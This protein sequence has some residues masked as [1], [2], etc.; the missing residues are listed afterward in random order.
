MYVGDEV[1]LTASPAGENFVWSSENEEVAGVSPTGLVTALSEGLSSV[2]VRSSGDEVKIDVRVRTFI[3]L[4]DISL[5][6]SS[7]RMYAGDRVQIWAYPVP[8]NASDV[9][10]A[11]Q[12]KNPNIATVDQNG[13][14]TAVARGVTTVSVGAGSVEKTIT[15]SVPELYKCNKTGWSIEVSDQ[16]ASDG[17]GKNKVIDDD[18]GNGGYWH[19]KW[20]GGNVPLPHWAIIDMKERVE[21]ARIVTQRRNNGDT[22]TLQYFISDS[23]D[24]DSETWTKVAEGMY[25]SKTASHTLTLDATE[26]VSG[27]YL[28]L[29]LPDSHRDVFIAI[30]EIDVYGLIY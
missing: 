30:C 10:F 27:R 25:A 26:P 22:K 21:C 9:K 20:D 18:Y 2:V 29:V 6:T 13:L 23:P 16:T 3:P 24:V 11:W 28:K 8:T 14:I 4:T 1:Q 12:S 19:S 5:S 15:V 17:G 7:V